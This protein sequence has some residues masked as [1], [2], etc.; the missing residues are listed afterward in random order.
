MKYLTFLVSVLA[1]TLL[2]NGCDGDATPA[3]LVQRSGSLA[4]TL[5]ITPNPPVPMDQAVLK[6]TLRDS[7]DRPLSGAQV[8]LD[9]TMPGMTM[10]LNRPEVK[11]KGNGV[12]EAQALFTMAGKWRI[13]A[14][15]TQAGTSWTFTF[16][17]NTKG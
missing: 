16:D 8:S 7:D 2:L 15:V 17:L 13:E 1:F 4:A 9:L 6:L 10:P 5:R 11:E 3:P 14:Q 12:Y